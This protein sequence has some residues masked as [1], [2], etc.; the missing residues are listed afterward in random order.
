MDWKGFYFT[1]EEL[2]LFWTIEILKN[3]QSFY[4]T[5]EELKQVRGNESIA[6]G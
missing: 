1:Y 2:K 5:Y 4:F 6:E 3:C